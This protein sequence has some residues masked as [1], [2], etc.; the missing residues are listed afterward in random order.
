MDLGD[1]FQEFLGTDK[2]KRSKRAARVRKILDKIS[3]KE[4]KL[5]KKLKKADKSEAKEI[6]GKLKVYGAHR[7]KAEKFLKKLEKKT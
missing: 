3:D 6:K 2:V 4:A 1:L 5:E 7:K